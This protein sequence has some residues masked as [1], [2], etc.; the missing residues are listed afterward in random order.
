MLTRKE[1]S[2][3]TQQDVRDAYFAHRTDVEARAQGWT[4][5]QVLRSLAFDNE[6]AQRDLARYERGKALLQEARLVV[7]PRFIR[8]TAEPDFPAVDGE[9]ALVPA[10]YIA[11]AEAVARV[12]L[13]RLSDDEVRQ[14]NVRIPATLY[15]AVQEAAGGWGGMTKW[16]IAAL[17]E[18]LEGGL[19]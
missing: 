10:G 5:E 8:G 3:Y 2:M 17:E 19:K 9:T 13:K 1:S 7:G 16:V 14:L 4:P 12:G 15:A 18:K 11:T 6:E